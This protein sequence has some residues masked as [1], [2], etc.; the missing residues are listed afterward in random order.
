MR[1]LWC[2]I[3]IQNLY[4]SLVLLG[5]KAATRKHHIQDWAISDKLPSWSLL[6]LARLLFLAVH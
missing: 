1:W 4:I 5:E 2:K 3:I 6:I